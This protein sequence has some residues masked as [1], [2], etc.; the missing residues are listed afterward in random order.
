MLLFLLSCIS[1]F[2]PFSLPCFASSF[3]TSCLPCYFFSFL[4]SSSARQSSQMEWNTKSVLM[5][6]CIC[7]RVCWPN[8][9][10]PQFTLK[11]RL[12]GKLRSAG[13]WRCRAA[14]NFVCCGREVGGQTLCP[15]FFFSLS[16]S[17]KSKRRLCPS[18]SWAIVATIVVV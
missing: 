13:W 10:P 7:V 11:F 12:L 5:L 9:S 6:V 14:S 1:T 18:Y 2:L 3:L 16:F 17:F 15:P 8:W 4:Q